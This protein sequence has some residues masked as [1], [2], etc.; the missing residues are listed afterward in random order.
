VTSADS[1]WAWVPQQYALG[2]RFVFVEG[3]SAEEMIAACGVDPAAAEVRT[4]QEAVD[5]YADDPFFRTDETAG[6]GFLVEE[7]DGD[8][9]DALL[10]ELSAGRRGVVVTWVSEEAMIGIDHYED[11]RLV[12][13]F[14]PEAP[15]EATPGPE[16]VLVR[17]TLAQVVGVPQRSPAE[18]A[19][20]TATLDLVTAEY[21]IRLD[22]EQVEGPLLTGEVEVDTSWL[23]D[24]RPASG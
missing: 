11:G 20:V 10:R 2:F 15:H 17:P 5:E 12:R 3:R 13:S 21:G 19:L 23:D 18:I 22:R 7:V 24:P 16:E 1:P 9:R 14:A 4:Q 6:W 8:D